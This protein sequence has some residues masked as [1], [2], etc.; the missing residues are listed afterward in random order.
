MHA[1]R[2][3][4]GKKVYIGDGSPVVHCIT[5]KYNRTRTNVKSVKLNKTSINLA[6][7]ES[8]ALVATVK[9]VMAKR[10]VLNHEKTV[11]F[12]SS[13]ANVAKVDQNGVVT[14]VHAGACTIYAISPNGVRASAQVTVT[15]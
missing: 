7:G 5:G 11:R 6:K 4:G 9:K 2:K 13:N 8:G 3:E 10:K 12:L 15:E 14:G 1:W